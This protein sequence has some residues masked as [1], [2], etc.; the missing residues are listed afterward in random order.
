MNDLQQYQDQVSALQ[1]QAKKLQFDLLKNRLDKDDIEPT[2]KILNELNQQ[3]DQLN[4]TILEIELTNTKDK[5]IFFQQKLTQIQG[6]QPLNKSTAY[7]DMILHTLTS[8]HPDH[9][10]QYQRDMLMVHDY[11]NKLHQE[12]QQRELNQLHSIYVKVKRTR[13]QFYLNVLRI[14]ITTLL[15]VALSISL[16]LLLKY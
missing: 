11:I 3:I 9:H 7:I 4:E 16:I 6:H 15:L 1:I 10:Y 2:K 12:R 14:S 5:A 8:L 13:R